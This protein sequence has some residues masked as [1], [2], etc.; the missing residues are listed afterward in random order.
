[1]M[2]KVVTMC[3]LVVLV[4]AAG[5]SALLVQVLTFHCDNDT[6][7]GEDYTAG[8]LVRD[9]SGS[10]NDGHLSDDPGVP[11]WIETGKYG[12]A[13]DFTGDG[14]TSGQSILVHHDESLNPGSGDFAISL[15]V[16]TRSN[17]D[18]DILRKGSAGNSSTWYKLEHSPAVWSNKLSLNFNTD[19]TD[20]TV[21]ST[22]AYD[23]GQWHFV[24]GQRQGDQ[25]QL[26]IDGVLDKTAPVSG[27]IANAA[28]LALGSKDTLDDDFFNGVLDDV[29]IFAGSLSEAEIQQLYQA[30]PEPATLGILGLGSLALLRKRRQ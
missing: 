24:V 28:N 22:E 11:T 1:M 20:A 3:V 17:Y 19:G 30:I 10:G 29:R 25:A 5:A 4:W 16:L 14:L 8:G 26:W 18:G 7:S 13:L 27:S 15:W 9:F 23:D 12:G 2:K 21:T 6:A